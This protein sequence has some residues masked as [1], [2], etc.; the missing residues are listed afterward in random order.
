M[1]I[2]NRFQL[3]IVGNVAKPNVVE[4]VSPR[5]LPLGTYVEIPFEFANELT[6]RRERHLLVGVVSSTLFRRTVPVSGAAALSSGSIYTEF[7]SELAQFGVSMVRIVTDMVDGEIITPRIPPPPN[8]PVY[9]ASTEVLR[10]LFSARGEGTIRIGHLLGRPDVEV[11]VSMDALVKHLFVTGTTGSGK[12]NTVAVL[13]DRIASEGGM[14]IVY[15]VHGEYA[16]LQPMNSNVVVERV[17]LAINPLKIPPRIL[18]RMIV[19][20]AAATVQRR[21]ITRALNEVRRIFEEALTNLSRSEAVEFI[22][23][24]CRDVRFGTDHEEEVTLSELFKQCL[25]SKVRS[26]RISFRE[27]ISERSVESLI[28]KIEEFFEY[29]P[30]DF[31]QPS[32]VDMLRPRKILVLDAL[33]L[34]DEQRDYLLKVVADEVLWFAKSKAAEGRVHPVLFVIEEAHLFL[35]SSRDT[36][37]KRSIERLAREGRKFGI[38]LV[39][40]S[41]RPRNIDTNTVSQIQNF[42]FMKL[43]QEQDQNT[44]MNVSDMLTED[45]ASSLSSLGTGEAIV[46]GEWVGRFPAFVKID[47]HEGKRVGATPSISRLWRELAALEE[48]GAEYAVIHEEAYRELIV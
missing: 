17:R 38:C 39:V 9:L 8:T 5:P 33:A 20:E 13:I 25:I 36:A 44:I 7:E 21:L 24:N 12:S 34:D 4:I 3:G 11:R 23:R 42:V 26:L 46:L 6:G 27:A 15:D 35:S 19:P 28:M 10:R 32:P 31:D 48:R 37:S 29:T 41:Q 18:A 30:I 14:V 16:N 43:V 40:V 45:L 47:K 22:A 1:S 2:D